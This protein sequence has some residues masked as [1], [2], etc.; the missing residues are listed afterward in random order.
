MSRDMESFKSMKV[1]IKD[2]SSAVA[3]Q[4][5][6]R[7]LVEHALTSGIEPRNHRAL[8]I[9][10]HDDAGAV[11]GGVVAATVWGWLHVKEMWVAAEHRGQ[12]WGSKLLALAE[13]EAVKRQCHHALLDTFDFQ[14]LGFYQRLG[15]EV[16]GSLNDFPTGHVRYFVSKRLAER[17]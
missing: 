13:D 6:E 9:L 7:G 8:V 11:V 12:G 16:F 4:A 15:Y 5:I 1:S 2:E 10:V 3:T 17:I 14:A